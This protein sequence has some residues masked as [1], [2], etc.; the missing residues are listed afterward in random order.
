MEK[1]SIDV[2][3]ESIGDRFQQN[4]LWAKRIA[5]LILM[6]TVL[7]LRSPIGHMAVILAWL[8]WIL[9]GVLLALRMKRL[10]PISTE[11]VW[12]FYWCPALNRG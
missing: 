12:Y 1:K 5:F 3:K 2:V 8:L 11:C 9:L 4:H 7:L 10:W 6:F